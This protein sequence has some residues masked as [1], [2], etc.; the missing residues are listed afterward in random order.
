MKNHPF[1]E[2]RFLQAQNNIRKLL[3]AL[4]DGDINSFIQITESEAL[5]LHAM[6]MTSNP[7]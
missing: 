4:K 7:F 3:Q 5:T 6:M 2:Q 1:A